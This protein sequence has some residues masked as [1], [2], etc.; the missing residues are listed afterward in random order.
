VAKGPFGLPTSAHSATAAAVMDG[1]AWT[2][3][4]Q[5][6]EIERTVVTFE[7]VPRTEFGVQ[8][9]RLRWK[10][11][12]ADC[13]GCPYHQATV[14]SGPGYGVFCQFPYSVVGLLPGRGAGALH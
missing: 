5:V 9:P 2:V 7:E 12:L 1:H 10:V 6:G 3:K 13:I 8:C 14:A 4:T 11:A